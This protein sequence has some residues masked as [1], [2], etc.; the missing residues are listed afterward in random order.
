MGLMFVNMKDISEPSQHVVPITLTSSC[1]VVDGDY[2]YCIMMH[3]VVRYD[4]TVVKE[5]MEKNDAGK[6]DFK[7]VINIIKVQSIV[8]NNGEL[9]AVLEQKNLIYKANLVSW[10]SEIPLTT[11]SPQV[12]QIQ[13]I[14]DEHV[15][16][17]YIK[18]VQVKRLEDD[19]V[20]CTSHKLI[21]LNCEPEALD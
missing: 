13:L 15:T 18:N 3:S 14:S 20:V 17:S 11:S 10:K 4:L 9:F 19:L 8:V 21:L 5:L 6:I 7:V 12:K 16:L 1:I 2:L